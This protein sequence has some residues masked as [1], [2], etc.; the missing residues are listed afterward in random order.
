[1][2]KHLKSKQH[3]VD[4]YDRITVEKCR[5]LERIHRETLKEKTPKD[6]ARN[7]SKEE[8]ARAHTTAHNLM[9]FFEKGEAHVNK[10]KTIQKWIERDQVLDDLLESAQ[11]PEDIR[12]LTCR[13][14]TKSTHKHVH[15]EG[16]DGENRVLFMLECPNGC[17]PHRAFFDDG[18]EWKLKPVLCPKCKTDMD[19]DV[20]R[21]GNP[22]TSIDTC[23]NC[24]HVKK[25]TY[26]LSSKKEKVDKSF[27][28]DRDRFCLSEKEGQDYI[29]AKTQMEGMSQMLKEWKE[30]E[31]HKDD[32][33]AVEKLQKLTIVDLE[34]LL[35]PLCK[36]H[37]YIKLTLNAPDMGKDLIVPFTVHDSKSERRDRASTHEL[38]K[39][40]KKALV[41]TNWRLMSGGCD[42][43]L[44][45]VTG[46]LR[47]YERDEDL[48]EL[49]RKR[50][51]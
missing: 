2:T 37:G 15:S 18:E 9:M 46:R 1:M 47:A 29:T 49:V 50:S 25:D 32:Y 34:K 21:K 24:G 36:K 5:R 3:Y 30:K 13:S 4:Q 44:G 39:L 17:L 12:C 23:P 48:L 16:L 42:Y 26:S 41:D 28:K 43:R 35:T 33:D 10:D 45:I 14:I 20:K 19:H 27:V 11:P 6:K 38:Q 8:I 22:I 40:I 51:K 7:L 31:K